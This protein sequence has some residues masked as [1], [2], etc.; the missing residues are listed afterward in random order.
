VSLVV[1]LGEAAR[2][3]HLGLGGAVVVTAE[4]AEAVRRCWRSMP[5]GVALVI[6]TERAAAALADERAHHPRVLR[7]VMST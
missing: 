2:V 7:V 6:L 1:A 5:D 4:D 3:R